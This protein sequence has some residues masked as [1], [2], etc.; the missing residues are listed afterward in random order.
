MKYVEGWSS[1]HVLGLLTH[2]IWVPDLLCSESE[3][4]N[5]QQLLTQHR[6]VISN[7]PCFHIVAGQSQRVWWN[8]LAE[9]EWWIIE[10]CSPVTG[11]IVQ[12]TNDSGRITAPPPSTICGHRVLRHVILTSA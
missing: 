12:V 1:A 7:L 10:I 9:K 3:S 5:L 4:D 2:G 11:F 6:Q 8:G